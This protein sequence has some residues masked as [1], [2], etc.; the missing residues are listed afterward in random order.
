MDSSKGDVEMKRLIIILASLFVLSGI[1]YA[2]GGLLGPEQFS[3]PQIVVMPAKGWTTAEIVGTVVTG[4]AALLAA[5]SLYLKY[6]RKK[7]Q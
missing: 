5:V 6:G 7:K 4:L 2:G 3:V 1:A